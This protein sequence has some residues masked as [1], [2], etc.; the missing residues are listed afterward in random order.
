MGAGVSCAVAAFVVAVAP[1]AGVARADTLTQTLAVDG[2]D[3][4]P[5][6]PFP[7]AYSSDPQAI[8]VG[9]TAGQPS[10]YSYVHVEID[11]L[12]SATDEKLSLKFTPFNG[13]Q[14]DNVNTSAAIL[15]MCVL[16]DKYPSPFDPSK[17]PQYDCTKGSAV[18]TLNSDGTWS[19]DATKLL[20][21]W[22]A[23]GNTGAAI[24]PEYQPTDAWEVSLDKTLIEADY[25]GVT[26]EST[27]PTVV[28]LPTAPP[29]APPPPVSV[30]PY[31]VPRTTATPGPTPTAGARPT[32]RATPRAQ[33]A[34]A[35]GAGTSGGSGDGGNGRWIA[36]LALSALAG[37]LLI[38]RPLARAV[39]GLAGPFRPTLLSEMRG[40][41][42]AFTL[43][44]VMLG[45]SVAFSGYSLASNVA[46][47]SSPGAVASNDNANGGAGGA[48]GNAGSGSGG[49]AGGAGSTGN[50]AAPG[51]VGP[52]LA[53]SSGGGA[54][55]TGGGGGGGTA[56]QTPFNGFG[57]NLFGPDRDRIG[58]D[59]NTIKL[60]GHSALIFGPAF[61]VSA[62][63][64][65]VFW[66]YVNAH[67][68]INGRQVQ[69]SW[70][71]DQYD[72]GKAVQ[73]AQAC[74][75]SGPFAILSGIGFDQ[76]PAVRVW[77]EQHQ[78]L[79]LYH[80][81]VQQ[82][83]Q[84]M[85]Y[86]YTEMPSVEQVG[87][88]AA[89]LVLS[90]YRGHK[91]AIIERQS[92][93]WEPGTAVFKKML[94]AAGA[95]ITDDEYVSN[96]QGTYTNNL[97]KMSQ[98]GADVALVWENALAA[99]EIIEQAHGQAWFPHMVLFPFNLTIQKLQAS[100]L[101]P[102]L[103]GVAAWTAYTHGDDAN[104]QQFGY[105]GEVHAFESAYAQYDP[106]ADL[107]GFGG[108]LL[109]MAWTELKEVADLLQD[110][111]RDCTRNK[112]AALMQG[113]RNTVP[114]NCPVD[115]NGDHHHA[116][117]FTD[118]FVG[119]ARNGQNEWLV[120]QHCVKP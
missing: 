9:V 90:K 49:G 18:G 47:A 114:P 74:E 113:Y 89:D 100:D 42:R 96:N 103:D 117:F 118:T 60:C 65:N 33:G 25:S 38:G 76:I 20:A 86:S 12:V 28:Y 35:A 82:G 81:A 70:N 77:A 30:A 87:R 39:S 106:Q 83:S 54:G 88:Q 109:W 19:F 64:I 73:A 79:Y 21:A 98:S 4:A 10:Y 61:N 111:G 57:V 62:A 120:T 80:I 37:L 53:S 7:D 72:P 44:S 5:V 97:V 71:D 52:N 94:A 34:T 50:P 1:G 31:H 8:H 110:C 92:P 102:P 48:Q 116:G 45:W 16:H 95:Q 107:S 69:M 75:D 67:G 66:Q 14:D 101:N 46:P 91:V 13:S 59:A 56:T 6:S 85:R 26:A 84:G 17:P 63:D 112:M 51:S 2:A 40:H 32:P 27:P 78:E 3:Y 15:S 55:G 22:R 105:A 29:T 99:T 36:A 58:I 24:I 68:G 104:A 93:N 119:E 41:P 115:F 108:D 43:A 23:D 11:G